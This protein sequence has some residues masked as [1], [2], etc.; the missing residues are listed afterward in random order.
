MQLVNPALVMLLDPFHPRRRLPVLSSGLAWES[1]PLRRM[2]LGDRGLGATGLVIARR[3]RNM[4]GRGRPAN[5]LDPLQIVPYVVLTV[6]EILVL[7]DRL[8]FAL[9]AGAADV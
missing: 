7:G 9:H 4:P 1:A 5:L 8:E 6:G 2:P 3:I